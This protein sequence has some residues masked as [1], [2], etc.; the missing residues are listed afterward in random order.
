MSSDR[1]VREEELLE[2][3]IRGYLAAD[4]GAHVAG[5]SACS[6]LR[7]VA[8]AVR[9]DR[10][11]AMAEAPVPSAA[12]VWWRVQLRER[13]RREA[14]A[15]RSLMIGQAAT[16]SVAVVLILALFGPDVFSGVTKMIATLGLSTPM[17]L[18]IGIAVSLA[19]I[20]GYLAIAEK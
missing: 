16:L 17:L 14:R 4:L 7:L 20:G 19:P 12:T 2:A 1:C 8:G 13:Q 9:D 3:L 15:R 18:A 11:G 6:E 10:V 5:C